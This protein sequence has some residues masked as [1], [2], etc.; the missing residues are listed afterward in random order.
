MIDYR[1]LLK[2]YIHLVLR[3]EGIDFLGYTYT[4]GQYPIFT[5]DEISELETLSD[6]LAG[7][8]QDG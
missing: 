6:E 5:E 1:D 3:Q 2:R 4:E 7:L 8:P